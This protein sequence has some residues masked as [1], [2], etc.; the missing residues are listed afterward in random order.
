MFWY[1]VVNSVTSNQEI[2]V[3]CWYN[4]YLATHCAFGLGAVK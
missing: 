3:G 4:K 1:K 2:D